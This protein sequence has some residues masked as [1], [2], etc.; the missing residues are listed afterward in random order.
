MFGVDRHQA[1]S[2]PRFVDWSG[3]SWRVRSTLDDHGPGPNAWSD[4]LQ[5]V[6]V[7]SSDVLTL[8]V[9]PD[10]PRWRC[11]EIEGPSLGYGKYSFEIATDPN[12]FDHKPVFIALSM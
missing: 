2:T 7:D 5:N 9:T 8:R 10:S 4:N 12:T 1:G 11:V 6:S 3:Y